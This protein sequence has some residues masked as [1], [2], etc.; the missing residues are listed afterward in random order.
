MKKIIVLVEDDDL[1]VECFQR[2]IRK[3]SL[4]ET[5][6][7]RASEGREALHTLRSILKQDP[8]TNLVVVLDLNMPGMNGLE[9]LAE[10]RRDSMLRHLVVFVL[11]SSEHRSDVVKAY[12]LG[13]SGYSSKEKVNKFV[14]FL[15]E[16]FSVAI[17]PPCSGPNISA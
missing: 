16:F 9:F 7:V 2:G 10:M 11:T 3:E 8:A 4:A 17:L 1:D 14:R 6:V 12:S 15:K 5:E 13:V